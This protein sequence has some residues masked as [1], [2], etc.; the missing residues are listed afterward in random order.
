[1]TKYFRGLPSEQVH[2]IADEYDKETSLCFF[3]GDTFDIRVGKLRL[4]G[5]VFGL[6][7]STTSAKK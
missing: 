2:I 4:K 6:E 7:D 3:A 5:E 1:M